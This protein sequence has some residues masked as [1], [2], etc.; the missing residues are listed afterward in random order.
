MKKQSSTSITL[1]LLGN[2]QR[3]RNKAKAE[4]TGN[5][6]FVHHWVDSR[7]QHILVAHHLDTFEAFWEASILTKRVFLLF[8][9]EA[10]DDP[11]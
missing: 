3:L 5:H 11:G 9:A 8:V 1:A 6:R 10:L 7:E 4:V 2:P